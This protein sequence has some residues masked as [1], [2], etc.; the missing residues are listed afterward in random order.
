MKALVTG[1]SGFI[2]SYLVKFLSNEGIEAYGPTYKDC[3]VRKAKDLEKWLKKTRPNF[4]FHLAAQS[5]PTISYTN[6]RLTFDVNVFGTIALFEC[7]RKLE[8]D[9]KVVVACSSAEYGLVKENE[10][11]VNEEHPLLPVHPYGVSKVAQDL[12]A[13]QYYKNYGIKAIRARIFNTTGPG[14]ENDVC[15][16]FTYGVAEIEKG[17][18]KKMYVGN[19]EPKRDITDVRDMVKALW[20]SALK[21]KDGEAY[22]LCSSKA[23]GIKEILEKAISL[24]NKKIEYEIDK[25]KLRPTDEPIILGDNRK[26]C[27]ATGWKPEISIEKTLKDMLNY[28]RGK[29][30]K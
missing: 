11:P 26:F 14:K 18:R 15:A 23:I 25:R 24:S 5:F 6:P 17:K 30:K 12:L 21:G 28:W 27:S 20:L 7:I 29:I 9:T 1:G 8:I 2:G 4:I 16:D 13:Y 19:L 10:V 22:N 3:D